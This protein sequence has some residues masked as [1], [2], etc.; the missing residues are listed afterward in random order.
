MSSSTDRRSA[1]RLKAQQLREAEQARERRKR[2]AVVTG[3]ALLVLALVVGIGIAVQ[4]SRNNAPAQAGG[5]AATAPRNLVDGGVVIGQASAPV[6]VTTY[7]DFQCP[8]C[9]SFEDLTG[10]TLEQLQESGKVKVVSRP[11]AILDRFSDNEYSTRS[12][13]AA[14]CLVDVAPQAYPAF[15]AA[16]FAQQPEENGSGLPD[17]QLVSVA[18]Q[19]GG[20]DISACVEDRTFEAW[21]RTT[22]DQASQ[23]GLQGTPYVLVNGEP[24]TNP[25]P[26]ALKAAVEAAG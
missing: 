8:A 24:L 16:L 13:N 19:A 6:T 14:A 4:A 26:D 1:A 23:D 3:A 11:V 20:P 2:T 5:G 10:P 18:Q 15:A 17:S 25:T 7:E 22:T 21:T 12:L 9:K